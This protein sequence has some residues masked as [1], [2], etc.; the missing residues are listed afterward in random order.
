[1]AKPQ[2][3]RVGDIVSGGD[4]LR[5]VVT[6]VVFDLERMDRQ[7]FVDWWVQRPQLVPN[8]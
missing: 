1:M 3:L 5:G 2:P 8:T 7:V 6:K 4:G